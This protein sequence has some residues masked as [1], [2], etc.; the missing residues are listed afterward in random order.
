MST[1][2]QKSSTELVKHVKAFP[3]LDSDT[4]DVIKWMHRS[5]IFGK[6]VE[7]A[8]AEEQKNNFF[9]I[10]SYVSVKLTDHGRALLKK[11]HD[12]LK[13]PKDIKLK[14]IAEVDGWSKW[15]LWELMSI[16]GPSVYL[17]AEMPFNAVIKI[18]P[19]E[20]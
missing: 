15:Q 2:L 20:G 14:P 11:Y 17:A 7:E 13:L 5:M 10:N 6:A 19:E 16:F 12:E 18:H 4:E 8:L 9:N 1:T 3:G